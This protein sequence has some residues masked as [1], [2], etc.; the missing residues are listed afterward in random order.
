MRT[1]LGNFIVS[2]EPGIVLTDDDWSSC[3]NGVKTHLKK[4]GWVSMVDGHYEYYGKTENSGC[5]VHIREIIKNPDIE[6]YEIVI[7]GTCDEY[8]DY[9]NIIKSLLEFSKNRYIVV[10]GKIFMT[11]EYDPTKT[12]VVLFCR[13]TEDI[14]VKTVNMVPT[15]L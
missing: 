8:C 10:V 14:I 9:E 15:N 5:D 2:A 12:S 3:T 4:N 13:N 6:P 11:D 1:I 7:S